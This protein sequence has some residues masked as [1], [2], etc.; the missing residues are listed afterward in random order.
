MTAFPIL[1]VL[2]ALTDTVE[3]L[4]F[5]NNNFTGT[6]PKEVF[7]VTS[8]SKNMQMRAVPFTSS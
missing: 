2:I 1:T 8:I 5:N 6:I 4:H 7:E 3:I